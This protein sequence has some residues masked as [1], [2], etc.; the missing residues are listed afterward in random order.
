M[1]PTPEPLTEQGAGGDGAV[2]QIHVQGQGPSGLVT[3][4]CLTQTTRVGRLGNHPSVS[5]WKGSTPLTPRFNPYPVPLSGRWSG[6]LG[7]GLFVCFAG[8]IS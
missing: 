7:F 2:G 1:A 3:M 8:V 6:F 5:H 4:V